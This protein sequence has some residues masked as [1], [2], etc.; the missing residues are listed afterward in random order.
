[1][2]VPVRIFFEGEDNNPKYFDGKLS[3]FLFILP[4]FTFFR[5]KQDSDSLKMEKK[6][7]LLFSI[8]F[9]L[10]AFAQTDMR[11]R[12][13]AP[14]IPP[15][16]LLSVMGLHNIF[17]LLTARFLL[18]GKILLFCLFFFFA[19]IVSFNAIYVLQQFRIVNPVEYL[20]GDIERDEYI[21]KYRPEYAA[22]KYANS[23]LSEDA[24]IL[25]FFLGN[26]SYYSNRE[27]LFDYPILIHSIKNRNMISSDLRKK[28]ITHLL[29]WYEMF[30]KWA[31]NNFNADEKTSLRMFFEENT[32]L[33]FSKGGH[34]LYELKKGG[35]EID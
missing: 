23:N 11:I 1:V 21:E 34:G 4:F 32:T 35:M 12:Y 30:N 2:L 5:I 26:R 3:P 6:I 16:V 27:M 13:I 22:I 20:R 14:V 31:N 24:K 17:L 7:L 29:I 25:C 28:G 33:L 8:L 19:L 15:L 9:V 18:S 10:F